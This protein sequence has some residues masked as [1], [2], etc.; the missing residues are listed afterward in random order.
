MRKIEHE[1]GI[2]QNACAAFTR[3]TGLSLEVMGQPDGRRLALQ[4]HGKKVNL[5]PEVKAMI[6][7]TDALLPLIRPNQ[8]KNFILVARQVSGTMAD[9]LRENGIQFMDE[10]GNAFINQPSLY[11]FVRGNRDPILK[12]APAIG[13]VFKQTGI[14]V[15]YVLLCNPGQENQP[16][17]TIAA[18]AE[19]AL[20][21]VNWVMQELKEL[22]FLLVVGKGK[23]RKIRLINK[24]RL[25]ERW[26]T[27]YAEQLRPKL[28]LGRYRGAAGWW[29]DAS[30][31]PDRALW[32]GEVAALKLTGH[33][34]P[35]EITIYL[36]KENLAAFL[37]EHK[38]KKDPAGDV[39]FV[40]R[41][42]RPD[43]VPPNRDAVNALLVYADLM[44]TGNQ[45]N[46]ETARMI[47]DQY[48]V[49]L[50]RET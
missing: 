17:R 43:A 47:Y 29:K 11:I 26:I 21:M 6:T 38:L 44:A 10:A 23:E 16:Y 39:E 1:K 31:D 42:W 37:I 19:V 41:F 25:L 3:M 35:Q 24:E 13:R 5:V 15:V 14:R 40:H 46:L 45:R 18:K 27:A 7:P 4:A 34:N 36:E 48:L 28:M 33:L 8:T 22:G 30:L 49:Q 9:K 20:G 12:K 2:L 50:V 32:G